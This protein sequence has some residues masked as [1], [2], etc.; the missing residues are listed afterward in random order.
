MIRRLEGGS[1]APPFQYGS[2]AED[3]EFTGGRRTF[4]PCR[5]APP[6]NA[7]V[8]PS[9]IRLQPLPWV[10][11]SD[12]VRFLNAEALVEFNGLGKTFHAGD[13]VRYIE[14]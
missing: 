6:S 2:L 5:F 7:A 12:Q 10:G 3:F 11:S 4:W 13:S 8:T 14:L 1:N 9:A